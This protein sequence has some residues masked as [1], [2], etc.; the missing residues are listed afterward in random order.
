M[1][2]C[3]V[4]S[5]AIVS[6]PAGAANPPKR[7]GTATWIVVDW[8]DAKEATTHHARPLAR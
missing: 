5:L 6:P 7:S 4:T 8:K 3:A 1:A 2:I